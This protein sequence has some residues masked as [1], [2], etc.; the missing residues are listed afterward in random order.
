MIQ[1]QLLD[2]NYK[3]CFQLERLLDCIAICFKIG[4]LLFCQGVKELFICE[5][6]KDTI[7]FEVDP[8]PFEE[9]EIILH[10]EIKLTTF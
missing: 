1:T 5:T 9:E 10:I 3:K 2:I 7:C 6:L 8:V 4:H